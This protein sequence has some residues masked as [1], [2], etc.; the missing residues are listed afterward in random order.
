MSRPLGRG[1]AAYIRELQEAFKA[2]GA[3]GFWQVWLEESKKAHDTPYWQACAYS[4]LGETDLAL[5]SLEEALKARDLW[6]T[7]YVMVDWTLD[8][9]RSE[10]RFHA[11]LN[12][13]HLE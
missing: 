3:K 11:I 5:D 13:M 6:L 4:Q 9:I 1:A 8:P 7:F 10:P 12:T 2:R